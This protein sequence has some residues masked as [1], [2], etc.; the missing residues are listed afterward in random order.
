MKKKKEKKKK[1]SKVTGRYLME[2]KSQKN[3]DQ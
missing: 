1:K 2:I 3:E